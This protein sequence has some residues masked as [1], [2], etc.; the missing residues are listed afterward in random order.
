MS[1]LSSIIV[2]YNCGKSSAETDAGFQP[3]FDA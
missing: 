2:I 3:N 1:Q